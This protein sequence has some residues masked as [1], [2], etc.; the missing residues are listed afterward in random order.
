ML[1]SRPDFR[2][3]GSPTSISN[4]HYESFNKFV[5]SKNDDPNSPIYC[6]HKFSIFANKTS[7]TVYFS[8]LRVSLYICNFF[9]HQLS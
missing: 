6:V 2:A 5:S 4:L 8:W 9:S 1:I 3:T 7:Q